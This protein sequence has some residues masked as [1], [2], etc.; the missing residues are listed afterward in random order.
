MNIYIYTFFLFLFIL[1]L[2]PKF[3]RIPRRKDLEL[4]LIHLKTTGMN[5]NNHGLENNKRAVWEQSVGTII[6]HLQ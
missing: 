1:T 3:K 4:D 6:E 5:G 2:K